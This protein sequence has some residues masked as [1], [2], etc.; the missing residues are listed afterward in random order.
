MDPIMIPVLGIVFSLFIAPSIVFGF[1]YYM[2]K[3]KNDLEKTKLQK[4]MKEIELKKE[5]T[6]LQ[7]LI[8]ENRKYDKMIDDN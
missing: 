4:E 8:Q 1:I 3:S 7:V 6:H 5:E 2:R